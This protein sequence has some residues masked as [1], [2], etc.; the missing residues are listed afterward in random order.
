MAELKV[1]TYSEDP[2]PHALGKLN[3][4]TGSGIR[5][6]ERFVDSFLDPSTRE[7]PD[8]MDDGELRPI[9]C[10]KLHLARLHSKFITPDTTAKVW[11]LISS[12][13]VCPVYQVHLLP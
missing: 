5:Y 4:L 10:A 7:L 8:P 1:I 12:P 9:L 3:R 11:N 6:Y 13:H 2:S